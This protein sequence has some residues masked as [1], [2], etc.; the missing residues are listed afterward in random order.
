MTSRNQQSLRPGEIRLDFIPLDWPLTPL[1][2]NKDPY[3]VGWQNKPF[4]ANEIEEEILTG[5]CKAVG[6]LGG[7]VYN[8]PYG[9]V[10]VDI[11]GPSVYKLIEEISDLPLQEAL[12]PTL[13]ISSGK[14]GR[15]RKLYRLDR[16][17]HKNFV[18]NKYTWTAEEN[19][20]KLEILWKRHQGVLMGLHPET[21]GYFTGE[22]LG[23]EWADKLPEFPE[24]LLNAILQKNVKQG[25]PP[26]EIVRTVGQ[27]FAVQSEITPER[28]I[29]LAI[30]ATWG[31]LDK[32]PEAV[33]DYDIWITVG[34]TLHAVDES[35][36]DVWDEWSKHS[37]KYKEG[38]CHR[39]WRSFSKGGGRSL[40]TL[41]HIAKEQGW[42][43]SENHRSMNVDDDTLDHY[44]ALLNDM[45]ENLGMTKQKTKPTKQ[46]LF[47]PTSATSV[48]SAKKTGKKKEPRQR[49]PSSNVITD[50]LLQE[51]CGS[52]LYSQSHGQ[53]FLYE[54][55]SPGL[56]SALTKV[57]ILGDIRSKLQQLGDFI[58][59]GFTTNLMN[60]IFSQLQSVLAFED[61]YTGSEYLLFTNGVLDV[62]TKELLPFDR[63]LHLTQQMPY[64]YDPS[65]TCEDIVKWLKHTQ[66]DSWERTQVLRAWLRATLLGRYE[67]QKFVEIVGPG[68]SGKSTYANLAVALVGKSNTYSTDFENMEK[69]RFE[70]ASYMGKKLLLFQDADRWG[71]S[72]SRLKAI[73][74]NDWIRSERKYQGETL[75]PF[76]YH[77]MVMITANEAIQSTDYTSGLARRRLTIPFDRPFTGGANA[78]KELMKFN[79]KGE[80]EG[81]FSP[82]LPGLV[83]WLLD[84][85]EE[86]MR[87]YLMETG[88]KV[89]FFQKYEKMQNLRSNPLL[90]WMEHKVVFDLGIRSS[91]G[92]TQT[93]IG[94]SSVYKNKDKW[95]YASYAEFCRE[96]NVGIMSRNRFE[97]L[98]LD[99]CA[100]QLKMNV[101]AKRN[102]RGM[103]VINVAV[104]ESD[105]KYE[106]WPSIV[107]VS[108]NKS[109]Y[110]EFY[111]VS[112]DPTKDATIEDDLM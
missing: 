24:W 70:S 107:E 67:I 26:K 49:N 25:V 93:V 37:S 45:E 52:L 87:E 80:P 61:W 36:L 102:S 111:G 17:K 48:S 29:Q 72:V 97:P 109:K 40:G 90:D 6:L 43:P 62:N 60:D 71:G 14:I 86:E 46:K 47:N 28:D 27:N 8:H 68:K 15:E 58:P 64:A 74:G 20:E 31:M 95:L 38:E 33:D 35:L 59:N 10:W 9:L 16:E 100:H 106:N 32:C 75:D 88:K 51:Y 42:A 89:K 50:V 22:D 98:F 77:G 78:Q 84:M 53:F 1:G 3:V 66:H 83:N 104:R 110:E 69:N 76:Q 112:L 63:E 39:R 5:N 99:I 4:T 34:Q 55:K 12:P 13:T 57:E 7:P 65:A 82:L 54:C 21:D 73:T 18:R 91:V 103:G 19:K 56:W 85:S 108:S 92:F 79:H 11:D 44:A 2:S 41:V 94:G 101:Y 30:E 96:C 81:I 105:S 23:F